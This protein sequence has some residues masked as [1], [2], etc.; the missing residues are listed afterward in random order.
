MPPE[1]QQQQE[2]RYAVTPKRVAIVVA[3]ALCLVAIVYALQQQVSTRPAPLT[4]EQIAQKLDSLKGEAS[5][6]MNTEQVQK[7]VESL[8]T[9]TDTTA[10]DT[11][12]VLNNLK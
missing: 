9:G 4:A 8:S 12:N 7:Q 11:A 6:T 5:T 3:V 10:T 2:A 1:I